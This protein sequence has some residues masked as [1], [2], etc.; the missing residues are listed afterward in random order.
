MSSAPKKKKGTVYLK[1]VAEEAG[2]SRMTASRSFKEGTQVRPELRARV[3]AAADKL[4]YKPDQ[5]ISQIM[6]SFAGQRKVDYRETITVLWWPGLWESASM[7]EGSYNA[8]ILRGLEASAT[9]H[10]CKIENIPMP[11][12]KP[13]R[14][15]DRM[16]TARNIQSVIITPPH[17]YDQTAP[18]LNWDPLSVVSIGTTLHTPHFHRSKM[19]HYGSVVL[20]LEKINELGCRRPCLL[21]NSDLE[22]RMDRAYTAAFM[23]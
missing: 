19:S 6:G 7:E 3:L 4:G 20:P 9:L 8:K 13:A 11:Q 21:V 23:A 12:D 15:I 5:M 2:V 16:L 22:Q 18:E 14:V 17:H 1:D 10:G